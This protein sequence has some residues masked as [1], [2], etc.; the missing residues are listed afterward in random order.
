MFAC[1]HEI[2]NHYSWSWTHLQFE[3]KHVHLIAIIYS[4]FANPIYPSWWWLHKDRLVRPQVWGKKLSPLIGPVGGH[5]RPSGITL[6]PHPLSIYHFLPGNQGFTSLTEFHRLFLS[7]DFQL[8]QT[9]GG[10]R[11]RTNTKG[12]ILQQ[13]RA[14]I[15][16]ARSS[17]LLGLRTVGRCNGQKGERRRG[18]YGYWCWCF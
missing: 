1:V 16:I 9:K 18:R 15:P 5:N 2:N 14:H 6:L 3:L 4:H 12:N 8:Q 7:Q 17:P 11:E 10:R 13:T